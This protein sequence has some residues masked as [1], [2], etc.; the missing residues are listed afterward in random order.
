LDTNEA[1]AVAEHLDT[2]DLPHEELR[3]A[4][5]AGAV[6]AAALARIEPSPE[7]RDRLMA[8]IGAEQKRVEPA[9]AAPRGMPSWTPRALA[10]LAAAAVIVLAVWNVSLQGQVAT[11]EA[12]LNRLAET[13]A[14]SGGQTIPVEGA[15]GRGVLVEGE[16]RTLL[17]AD[18]QAPAQGMLY[19]MWLIGPDGVPIDVGTFVPEAGE[20]F[21]V[22]ELERAF[23]GFDVFAVTLERSRVDAPSGD[24]VMVSST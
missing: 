21:V 15:A 6:L 24:P 8:S 16:G 19:E 23:E 7:L 10:A 14:A 11:R 2:C 13:L 18:V 5:G 12:A 4:V 9:L 1:A 20:A 3:Q 22:V 17:V